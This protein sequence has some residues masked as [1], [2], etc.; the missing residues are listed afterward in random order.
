MTTQ[1]ERAGFEVQRTQNLGT[2]YSRTLYQ[3]LEE[4]I[5]A[6]KSLKEKYGEV[7]DTSA[8]SDSENGSDSITKS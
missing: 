6:E 2:H 1:L 8:D 4:W 7:V 3:W 5:K